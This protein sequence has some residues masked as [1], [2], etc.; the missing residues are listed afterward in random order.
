MVL[1]ERGGKEV[2]SRQLR[3]KSDGKPQTG[4]DLAR[5]RIT[6]SVG[7]LGEI[8][9]VAPDWSREGFAGRLWR[10]LGKTAPLEKRKG[11]APKGRSDG[12]IPRK[13]SGI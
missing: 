1:F 10:G 5:S 3:I 11:V 9:G 13:R 8:D 6:T 4:W 12:G 7:G 2:D